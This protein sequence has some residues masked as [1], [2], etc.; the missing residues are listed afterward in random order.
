MD[1]NRNAKV[2]KKKRQI[3]YLTR[4]V[5]SNY[6]VLAHLIERTEHIKHPPW[7]QKMKG[8]SQKGKKWAKFTQA[9]QEGVLTLDST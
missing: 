5:S 7:M 8:K 2:S 9:F 4:I 3:D 1:E 6:C